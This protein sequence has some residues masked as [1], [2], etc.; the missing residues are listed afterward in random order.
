MHFS[1]LNADLDADTDPDTVPDRAT[2]S[3]NLK[4]AMTA[5]TPPGPATGPRSPRVRAAGARCGNRK[6]LHRFIITVSI[7]NRFGWLPLSASNADMRLLTMLAQNYATWTTISDCNCNAANFRR[8]RAPTLVLWVSQFD[9][10]ALTFS[11]SCPTLACSQ[12]TSSFL[13]AEPLRTLAHALHSAR[14]SLHC[15]ACKPCRNTGTVKPHYT[16]NCMARVLRMA[17]STGARPLVIDAAESVVSGDGR[18]LAPKP[19][20]WQACTDAGQGMV[21]IF[22]NFS[23]LAI[24]F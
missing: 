1:E 12:S 5:A 11:L 2:R 21:Y 7:Y 18:M 16:G 23:S 9:V 24:L 13:L 10:E 15:S 8:P 4:R 20:P 6:P 19:R 22:I 14:G 17:A 3:A